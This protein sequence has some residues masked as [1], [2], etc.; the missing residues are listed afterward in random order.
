MWLLDLATKKKEIM[1]DLK[2]K[3]APM[4]SNTEILSVVWNPG[5]D[6]FLV[7]TNNSDILLFTVDEAQ[8]KMIFEK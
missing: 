6:V 1:Y 2:N 7:L 3:E 8:P 4:D 5:E